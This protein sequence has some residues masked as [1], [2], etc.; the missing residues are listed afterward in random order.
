M[1]GIVDLSGGFGNYIFQY[2]FALYLKNHG[3]NTYLYNPAKKDYLDHRDFDL[4][5]LNTFKYFILEKFK[6]SN[7]FNRSYQVITSHELLENNLSLNDV[8]LNKKIISF[9][10]FFQDYK[11]AIKNLNEIKNYFSKNSSLKMSKMQNNKNN[12]LV[13][14]RRSDYLQIGEELDISY[15][16]NAIEYCKKN[17]KN[18]EFDVY[19]DDYEWVKKQKIFKEAKYIENSKDIVNRDE[20]SV[21]STFTKM[22]NYQNYVIANS[23]YS[24]WAALLSEQNTSVI[25]QPDPFF[26]LANNAK[27]DVP[28]WI[29]I[30]RK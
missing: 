1:I 20:K 25:I 19:T 15:Y 10:G 4:K 29:K 5:E 16:E 28:S 27:M 30:P 14:V 3:I 22:L 26:K 21:K 6:K 7:S 11:I 8:Y 24:W 23:T 13:H 18:F 17:I 2:S 12:T 9:N